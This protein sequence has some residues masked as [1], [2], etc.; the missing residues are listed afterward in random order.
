MRLTRL[1]MLMVG[2]A[3]LA[4]VAQADW[5]P[6][7]RITW[8][9]GWS[10]FSSITTDAWGNI[11]VVWA[12]NTP[13]NDEIF[14]KKS[15][16]GGNNWTPAKR[17]SWSS[18]QSIFPSIV[19]DSSGIIHV[20]YEDEAPILDDIFYTKSTD[21]GSTWTT[22]KNLSLASGNSF[23]G[24]IVV[25]PS[26][27]LFVVWADWAVGTPSNYEI[28]YAKS[29]DGGD[30][31][32]TGQRITWTAG[33]SSRTCVATDPSGYLHV[34]WRDETPGN[35][36]V[37][38]TKS[39][40]GGVSWAS[41]KRITWTSGSSDYPCIAVDPSGNPHVVWRDDTPGNR[42][43]YYRKSSDGGVTWATARRLTW[44]S[45]WTDYPSIAADSWGYLHVVWEDQTDGWEIYYKISTDGG[46]NWAP[47]K[48]ITWGAMD[49]NWPAITVDNYN[50]LYV[51]W[52][53]GCPAHPQEIYYKYYEVEY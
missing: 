41:A 44:T 26:G 19:V 6:A 48:R 16:Y 23:I 53:Y 5:W 34:V 24:N 3:I 46:A 4:Q 49:C 30:S 45:S 43:I 12:D 32:T 42:E 18:G 40:D 36:E 25:D 9:S 28:F 38:Y 17:L 33:G 31:W 10:G 52:E 51:V 39:T 50:N 37:Y 20:V 1:T 35:Q 8:T 29:T 11:Y 13:G 47:N 15:S 2:L 27:T 21:G 14:Y 22:R 7:K